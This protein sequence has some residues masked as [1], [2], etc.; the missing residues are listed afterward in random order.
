MADIKTKDSVKRTIKTLDK[1]I[2]G[3]QKIK[4][5]YI[6]TKEAIDKP[7]QNNDSSAQEYA[8]NNT[9]Q[10]IESVTRAA[11]SNANEVGYKSYIET[12]KNIPKVKD[13]ILSAK[14]RFKAKRSHKSLEKQKEIIKGDIK[15]PTTNSIKTKDMTI[16]TVNHSNVNNT[17]KSVVQSSKL[18]AEKTKVV[19]ENTKKASK[20]LVSYLRKIIAALRSLVMALIAGGWLSTM[21][22]IVIMLI[23]LISGSVFGIFFSGEDSGNGMTM[24]DAVRE[25]NEEYEMKLDEEKESVDYD[26]LEMSGNRAVWKDV[27]SV[28]SVKVNT[29]ETNPQEVA[30]MNDE[31]KELL[32]DIFWQMNE[33]SSET[34]TKTETVIVETDDGEGNIVEEET[35]VTQKYLYI[36]VSHKTI[37]EMIEEYNFNDKQKALLNEL[38]KEENNSLWSAV[39]YGIGTTD[40]QIVI[41]ALSQVGNVGGQPYW[42]WYGFSSRVEWCACFVSWCANECGYI[43]TGIIPKF[44]GCVQGSQWF[45]DRGQWADRSHEPSAGTIIFFDWEND[46]VTDHVGIVERCENGIVYTVEGN[47][48][49]DM[50]RQR[51]YSVGSNVIYGYGI[52]AY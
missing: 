50:C 34:E 9:E 8:A 15:Q 26:V 4:K 46:G 20:A 12:K 7:I 37:D 22:I 3:T 31:K 44:A 27:L 23:A 30:T 39:L 24:K 52:P 29:D 47:S 38:L 36:K 5:E 42:S 51:E 14:E 18:L 43:D 19:V 21:V 11:M 25:I 28:Y 45:M 32:K 48:L 41:I 49:N 13:E 40:G 16:K 1:A 10:A 2:V 17:N 33:I 35:E 6:Q